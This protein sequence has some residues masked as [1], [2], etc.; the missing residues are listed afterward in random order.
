[1]IIHQTQIYVSRKGDIKRKGCECRS[2]GVWLLILEKAVELHN[3]PV[4][5]V[6]T[7]P[8]PYIFPALTASPNYAARAHVPVATI[9]RHHMPPSYSQMIVVHLAHLCDMLT[10]Y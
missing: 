5:P 9:R 10:F 7:Q 4:S 6:A 8:F 1:M 3:Q 2:F